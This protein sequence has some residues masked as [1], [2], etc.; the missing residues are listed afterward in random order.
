MV[1]L[2]NNYEQPYFV[3]T[4][5][6]VGSIMSVEELSPL[7]GAVSWTGKAFT[8]FIHTIDRSLVSNTAGD[9]L[10]G[11]NFCS[12]NIFVYPDVICKCY[13]LFLLYAQTDTHTHTHT[14]THTERERE[15]M[16]ACMDM[17][18]CMHA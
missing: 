17:C 14:H 15:A 8:Y 7:P 5:T 2:G 12:L 11:Y 18:V 6:D 4:F 13:H 1:V 10:V 3:Y 16:L 9:T